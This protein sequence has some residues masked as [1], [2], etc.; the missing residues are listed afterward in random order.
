VN[1][2]LA[3]PRGGVPERR[4]ELVEQATD[5]VLAHGLIGLSLRPLAASIGT[6]DRMLLYH[7][8]SKADLVAAVLV[9]SNDRSITTVASLPPGE[10]VAAS[11]HGLWEAMIGTDLER[12]QRV[13]V[14][15]SA[16]GLFG[17][18]P[19]A[20]AVRSANERW[21]DAVGRRL[22][23]AGCRADRARR[24]VELV[25]SVMVGLLLDRSLHPDATVQQQVVSDL[26]VAVAAMA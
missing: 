4:A 18:E 12:C 10:D 14:E 5:Y 6:S 9:A 15:A 26:A 1:A 21:M 13:Y 23:A 3:A 19:Y 11:V 2:A 20:S 22:V 8:E 16:L 17:L 7:F 25:D 24:A